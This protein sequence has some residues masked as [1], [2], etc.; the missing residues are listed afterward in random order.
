MTTYQP[1]PQ[2]KFTFG[3]MSYERLDPLTAELLLGVR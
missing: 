1:E 3:L 2:H